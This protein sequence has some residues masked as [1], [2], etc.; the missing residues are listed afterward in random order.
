M[1]LITSFWKSWI[2]RF[3]NLWIYFWSSLVFGEPSSFS[4]TMILVESSIIL[5]QLRCTS[6]LGWMLPWSIYSS[7]SSKISS[8]ILRHCEITLISFSTWLV[9]TSISFPLISKF[10]FWRSFWWLRL[11]DIKLH[12]GLPSYDLWHK[13]IYGVVPIGPCPWT[14]I[15]EVSIQMPSSRN[16]GLK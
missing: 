3:S 5:F 1:S 16:N 13:I 10:S 12:I 2:I 4:I 6:V 14:P 15:W 9:I 8:W 11:K 7:L